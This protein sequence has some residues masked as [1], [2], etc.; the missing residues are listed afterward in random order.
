ML[1][2][3]RAAAL[4]GAVA[5]VPLELLAAAAL[6]APKGVVAKDARLAGDRERTRFIADLS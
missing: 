1:R 6:P 3:F 5:L 4:L 2:F